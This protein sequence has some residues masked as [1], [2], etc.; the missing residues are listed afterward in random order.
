[1]K[2]L[3]KTNGMERKEWLEWRRMGIGG[4]IIGRSLYVCKS[5]GFH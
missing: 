3:A 1:M 4:S 2:V 5:V